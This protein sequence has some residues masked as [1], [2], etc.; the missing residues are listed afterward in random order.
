MLVPLGSGNGMGQAAPSIRGAHTPQL[1]TRTRLSDLS[2][3]CSSHREI[4]LTRQIA[5]LNKDPWPPALRMRAPLAGRV[6][7]QAG[8]CPSPRP[9]GGQRCSEV[10]PTLCGHG[11]RM[12]LRGELHAKPNKG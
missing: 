9:L 3:C 8:C 2:L 5:E 7:T 4:L 10:A 1:H 12:G 11:A 6:P